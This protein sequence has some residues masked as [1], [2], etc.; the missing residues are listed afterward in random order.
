MLGHEVVDRAVVVPERDEAHAADL[1]CR[2][3]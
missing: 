2:K 1:R 3:A